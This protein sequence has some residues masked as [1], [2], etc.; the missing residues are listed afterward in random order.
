MVSGEFHNFRNIN[1]DGKVLYD[2]GQFGSSVD[3]Y[4]H[5]EPVGQ[6]DTVRE[7]NYTLC[8][9][10]SINSIIVVGGATSFLVSQ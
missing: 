9:V 7:Y 10:Y 8:G 6:N 5:I 3:G 2:R 1:G 4:I